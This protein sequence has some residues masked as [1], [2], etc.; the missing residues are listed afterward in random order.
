ML[1]NKNQVKVKVALEQAIKAQKR[2]RGV[3][4]FSFNLGAS[5]GWLVAPNSRPLYPQKKDF[6]PVVYRDRWVPGPV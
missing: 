1:N 5:W 3:P 2:R 6:L 4:L